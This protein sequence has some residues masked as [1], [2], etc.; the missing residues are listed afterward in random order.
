MW[1]AVC[2][3]L[4]FVTAYAHWLIKSKYAVCYLQCTQAGIDKAHKSSIQELLDRKP[5]K[6]DNSVNPTKYCATVLLSCYS[7]DKNQLS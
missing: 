1:A 4:N 6:A 7:N 2:G 5:L 3:I